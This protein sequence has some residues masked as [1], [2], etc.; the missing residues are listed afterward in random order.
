MPQRHCQHWA[1]SLTE[2]NS[3]VLRVGLG[4][5]GRKRQQSQLASVLGRERVLSIQIPD[6]LRR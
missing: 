5:Y 1:W 4:V 2:N 3:E 6:S